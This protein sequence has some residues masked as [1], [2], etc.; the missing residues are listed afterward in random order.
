MQQEICP[1]MKHI[2]PINDEKFQSRTF[3]VFTKYLLVITICSKNR[4]IYQKCFSN[5]Q[6]ANFHRHLSG[7]VCMYL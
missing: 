4:K 7:Y 3:L 1:H 2:Y 6:F 5:V